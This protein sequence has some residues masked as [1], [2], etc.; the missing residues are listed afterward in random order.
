MET[1]RG[2]RFKNRIDGLTRLSL[3]PVVLM[4]VLEVMDDEGQVF[5]ELVAVLEKNSQY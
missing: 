2:E 3:L 1:G 4:K 5:S